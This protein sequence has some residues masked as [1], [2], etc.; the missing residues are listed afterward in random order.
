LPQL[1]VFHSIGQ[2]FVK[3]KQTVAAVQQYQLPKV[4]RPLT[5][6]VG[7]EGG[8]TALLA[9]FV[10]TLLP[11]LVLSRLLLW[12]T[13]IWSASMV[14]LLLVVHFASLALCLL[15]VRWVA[16]GSVPYGWTGALALIVPGQL[17]WLLVDALR[18]APPQQQ[19]LSWIS[20][21]KANTPIHCLDA[22]LRDVGGLC[23]E[24]GRGFARGASP[25]SPDRWRSAR[26]D[27]RSSGPSSPHRSASFAAPSS[28]ASR[29]SPPGLQLGRGALSTPERPEDI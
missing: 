21:V 24:P 5:A 2:R 6:R 14:R 20:P 25:R 22:S 15:A 7:I 27:A 29:R 13:K 10:I 19:H 11:T 12:L 8:M 3:N 18:L 28:Y 4:V 23:P 9:D 26:A 17:A 1:K 16:A